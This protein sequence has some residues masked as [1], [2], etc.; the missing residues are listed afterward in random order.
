MERKTINIRS[1][2]DGQTLY[3]DLCYTKKSKKGFVAIFHGMAEHRFRYEYFVENLV[4]AGYVVLNCDHRGHGESGEVLGYF[5]KE[6]GWEVNVK[7]LHQLITE[8]RKGFEQLP[9]IIFGHSMGTLFARSYAKRYE[10]EIAGL[11]LSGT[12]SENPLG[13]IGNVIAK[14]VASFKGEKHRSKL[15]DNMSFGSFNKIVENP[16]TDYDWLSRNEDNVAA[17]IADEKCG[18]IFTAKGFQDVIFGLEDVYNA[19]GWNPKNKDLPI[20]FF[21]GKEDPCSCV[22]DGFSKAVDKLKSFGYQKVVS[23]TYPKLRHE[24]LNENERDTI[25]ADMIQYMDTEISK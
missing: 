18:F 17:Y 15:L 7:D 10:D 21:S 4:N 13:G 9:L 14:M 6:N 23:K 3:G 5:A 11:V 19:T 25:I 16:K 20:A 2:F 8:G 22:K 12:P 1:S 24:I